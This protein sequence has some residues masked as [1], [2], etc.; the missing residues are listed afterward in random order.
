MD[1]PAPSSR[2]V[3][4]SA[5]LHFAVTQREYVA[6]LNAIEFFKNKLVDP[7]HRKDAESAFRAI[8][9]IT[10]F[11]LPSEVSIEEVAP[12]GV[13][14]AARSEKEVMLTGSS[15][16]SDGETRETEKRPPSATGA[17]QGD[18]QRKG[19]GGFRTAGKEREK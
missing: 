12:E 6:L 8:S 2:V 3:P 7:T 13:Q 19:F 5:I 10:Y 17:T 4:A 14:P 1:K 16:H 9:S 15:A 11:S 18:A